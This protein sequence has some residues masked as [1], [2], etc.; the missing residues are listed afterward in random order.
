[1]VTQMEIAQRLGLDVSTV[2]KVLNKAPRA[3]FKK[4]TVKAIFKMVKDLG[5]K[6]H[7]ASKGQM[8]TILEGLFPSTQ[9][10]ISL[11]VMRGLAPAEVARIKRMLYGEPDFKL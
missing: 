7:S 1:M 3:S 10:D 11:A 2:N 9:P 5:Y 6:P 8:R 4:E